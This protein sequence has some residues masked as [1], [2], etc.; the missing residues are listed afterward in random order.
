MKTNLY[1]SD[2]ELVRV[3]QDSPWER[4]LR[5]SR[6]SELKWWLVTGLVSRPSATS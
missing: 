4:G 5:E 2:N 3:L 1:L 6:L